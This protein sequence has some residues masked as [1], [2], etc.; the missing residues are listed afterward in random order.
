MTYFKKINTSNIILFIGFIILVFF[1]LSN[2]TFFDD[3]VG[4]IQVIKNFDNV[5]DL[6]LYINNWDVSPPLSYIIVYLSNLI[7][8][9]QYVPII[10]LPVQIVCINIFLKHSELLIIDN[11]INKFIYKISIIF[12]PIFILWC[13][14]LR[15]YSL[16]VPLALA[17]IGI[18]YF[19]KNIKNKDIT[20][21]F[22]IASVM[23]HISY[24]TIVFM[25]ALIISNHKIIFKYIVNNKIAVVLLFII[26]LPQFYFLAF[27]H[28]INS[29]SQ[30]GNI[31]YSFIFP[32]IT[33]I[34]GN[35]F[36]PF[37]Y[38]SV[39][40]FLL[41]I[42]IIFI[43][44]KNH[45][46]INILIKLKK[47]IIFSSS[48]F[49][50]MFLLKIGHKPRH[51]IILNY[52]FCFFIFL[53]LSF[54][55]KK[56]FK[57]IL[58]FIFLMI[59]FLGNKNNILEQNVIKNNINLPIKAIFKIIDNSNYSCTK[60]YIFTHNIKIKHF[61]YDKNFFLV[62]PNQEILNDKNNEKCIYIIKSFI[63]GDDIN[64]VKYVD[65]LFETYGNSFQLKIIEYDKFNKLKLLF[66]KKEIKNT[67]TIK[68][69]YN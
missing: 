23:F 35:S 26:N 33:T 1:R 51:S 52:L 20:I 22:L 41:L 50:L 59:I 40:Y 9:Y 29:P 61:F 8:S 45:K 69:M 64:E 27:Q 58:I 11:K 7:F 36:L 55:K 44:L 14:S 54:I 38:L 60:K 25:T 67:F 6:Y 10:F 21:I 48:F 15:W 3:E 42:T 49:L 53:N 66:L 13:T 2:K 30:F 32:F 37:E 39:I 16:W 19:K 57:S 28:L 68:I 62:N 43:N 47:V 12:N 63:G 34:F 18:F 4:S 5:I 65:K 17:I 56:I 31:Y 24:L 46:F